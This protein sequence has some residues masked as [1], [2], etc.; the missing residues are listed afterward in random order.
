[1]CINQRLKE[2]KLKKTIFKCPLCKAEI[3]TIVK[4]KDII[5]LQNN[6]GI[7]SIIEKMEFQKI[8]TNLSN[9]SMSVSLQ[10]NNSPINNENNNIENVK[11]IIFKN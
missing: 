10:I 1:M 11:K 6:N 7:L 8:R 5:Q 3:K 9:T 4:N 2:S